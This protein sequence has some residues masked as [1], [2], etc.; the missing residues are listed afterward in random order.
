MTMRVGDV[1]R[2]P[3]GERALVGDLNE[4]GGV[5]DDCT[6]DSQRYGGGLERGWSVESNVYDS[7]AAHR[8]IPVTER[9]P[10]DVVTVAVYLPKFGEVLP[11][12]YSARW[13]EWADGHG[14]SCGIAGTVW[15]PLPDPPR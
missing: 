14:F 11:L 6:H 15:Q 9:L 7:L 13:D 1:L 4:E 12:Y 10:E 5:C 2:G 8:W 3:K